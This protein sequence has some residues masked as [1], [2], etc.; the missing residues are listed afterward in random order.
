V[1]Q[2]LSSKTPA[3]FLLAALLLTGCLGATDP[4]ACTAGNL[5]STSAGPAVFTLTP[6]DTDFTIYPGQTKQ[7][8]VQ[9]QSVGGAQ[10][11][12]ILNGLN[13]PQGVT[14]SGATASI[15][16]TAMLT[17]TAA[18]NVV[19]QCFQPYQSITDAGRAI[20][21]EATSGNTRLTTQLAMDVVLENPSFVPAATNLPVMSITTADAA[22]IT[23]EDDYVDAKLSIVDSVH[24]SNNYTGTMG[25]KGHGNSTW[26]MP[27]KPYRLNLDSKAP[28]LGMTSDSNWILLANYD[29]KTMLRNDVS[30]KMSQMFGM[31][32]TPSTAFVEVYLN[33]AYNGT[34]ELSEKVEVSK[35]RLNIGSIDDTDNSGTDL[36]GGYLGEIDHYDGETF[37]MTSLVGLPI[38]IADPDPPTTEQSTYFSQ[39][40]ELAENSMYASNFTDPNSGWQSKWD[41]ASVVNWFLVEELAGNQDAN[42][43]SSDYFYKPRS[44]PKFYRG[45]VWDMDITFGNDYGFDIAKPDVPWVSVKSQWYAQLFKDPAFKAAVKAQWTA[46][47]PQ[48]LTLPAYIDGRAATL[49]LAA[50]NNFGRWPI[51]GEIV[52]PNTEAAGTYNGEVEF[53][54]TWLNS[55]I[56]YMDS[57]YLQQ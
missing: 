1:R 22:P 17:V 12:V 8:P 57:Q 56:A 31:A 52:W 21:I 7:I 10:G 46:I 5:K 48:V 43:W 36:T 23:S 51:L 35:A 29:D 26:I 30:F 15:G 47:R 40:F 11:Q 34:Y 9:I 27:K 14:I 13:L 54:K 18:N 20:T 3:C 32:W 44:D 24:P 45:P 28:L 19:A 53:M 33:G 38:G 2:K 39:N 25:I 4:G 55:R 37:M 42:D 50:Q 41:E 49:D 16:S 6:T